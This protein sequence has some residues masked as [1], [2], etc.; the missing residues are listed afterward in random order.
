M[1]Q[2]RRLMLYAPHIPG[3][4]GQCVRLARKLRRLVD[5]TE[6]WQMAI[7]ARRTDVSGEK[8]AWPIARF[9]ALPD[10][11]KGGEKDK[12]YQN[13]DVRDIA[14]LIESNAPPF[15]V[16]L[17]PYAWCTLPLGCTAP[18]PAPLVACVPN[19]EF[20]FL[21]YGLTT[22]QFRRDLDKL[23]RMEAAFVFA[24]EAMRQRAIREFGVAGDRST[25]VIPAASYSG[26]PIDVAR[27]RAKYRLPEKYILCE[28][29]LKPQRNSI[30]LLRALSGMSSELPLV[31]VGSNVDEFLGTPLVKEPYFRDWQVVA[32]SVDAISD[33]D[34]FAVDDI[35]RDDLWSLIAGAAA[36]MA[37]SIA[38]GSVPTFVLDA[39]ALGTPVVHSRIA[40][41]TEVLGD[42]DDVAIGCDPQNSNDIRRALTLA[43]DHSDTKAR[44]IEAGRRLAASRTEF[45]AAR[46]ILE[47]CAAEIDRKQT[48]KPP[49]RVKPAI[50]REQRV[51]WLINHTT[52][53]DFEVPLIQSLG[54][55][56]YTSKLLPKGNDIISITVDYSEDENTTLPTWVLNYLNRQNLYEDHFSPALSEIL[57][58]YF[59]TV[60]CTAVGPMVKELV[61]HY[62]GRI[63]IRVF[64]R[65]H[66]HSYSEY[67]NH[68]GGSRLWES[69]CGIQQRF[70]FAQCYESIGTI[71]QKLIQDRAL[72]LPLG[73]PDRILRKRGDWTG[74]DKR[75]L[76]VCSRIKASPTYYGKIYDEFKLY[77]GDL[78]H[79][80]A[81]TQPLPVNDDCVSGFVPDHTFRLWLREFRVM[82]YHS[83]EPR[84][85]HYHPLEAVVHGMPLIYMKGGLLEGYG[86]DD[87][88]GACDTLEEARKKVIRVLEDDTAFIEQLQQRQTALL[89]EFLWDFNRRAWDEKLLGVALA[90][91]LAK[92]V[93]TID[94]WNHPNTLQQFEPVESATSSNEPIRR[95][96]CYGPPR[97]ALDFEGEL[98][99]KLAAATSTP[100]PVTLGGGATAVSLG[101][102][103]HL[104]ALELLPDHATPML[105]ASIV[106]DERVPFEWN[107]VSSIVDWIAQSEMF[108]NRKFA[109]FGMKLGICGLLYARGAWQQKTLIPRRT[110]IGNYF[111]R[112]LLRLPGVH[113]IFEWNAQRTAQAIAS[114]LEAPIA[115]GVFSKFLV[116]PPAP[117][118]RPL[119][120]SVDV[121][122]MDFAILDAILQT[123]VTLIPRPFGLLSP[124][125]PLERCQP[126]AAVVCVGDLD[127]EFSERHG[128][129]NLS[130]ARTLVLWSRIAHRLIFATH[131]ARDEAVRRYGVPIEK[132]AVIAWPA[133]ALASQRTQVVPRRTLPPRYLLSFDGDAGDACGLELLR[134]VQLLHWRQEAPPPVI[135]ARRRYAGHESSAFYAFKAE[136]ERDLASMK[137][138]RGVEYHII[139]IDND[140][141]LP[142]LYAKAQACV[143]TSR[144]AAIV[145]RIALDAFV[146]RTPVIAPA[147]AETVERF[148]DEN[149][150][151]ELVDANDATAIADAIDRTLVDTNATARRVESA[152][153]FARQWTWE[154]ATRA[155]LEVVNET[156]KWS[157]GKGSPSSVVAAQVS[158]KRRAAA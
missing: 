41:Y 149:R 110:A 153:A 96:L 56:V 108:C 133:L 53:R 49:V 66:P 136:F 33:R 45:D 52:L 150:L 89:E 54:L 11:A 157:T 112:V 147:I 13:A 75:V 97:D 117:T 94:Q 40:A 78:P 91:P 156:A 79:L 145:Q 126:R 43:L 85:L 135:F 34:Y 28:D 114:G 68:F 109:R 69:V 98:T 9:S 106:G 15:D 83:R 93:P 146:Y 1:R 12:A 37:P 144:S 71:E 6:G 101:L 62:R 46:Q 132:T 116:D 17:L 39:L 103:E 88:P 143:T 82:F 86:G 77:F 87:Q 72:T 80:I 19:L 125:L 55:E 81:G 10:R 57:N 111:P 47:V 118:N 129:H 130:M 65:E 20:D 18:I 14:H 8:L 120:E 95:I 21:D 63:M 92:D 64:G 141:E 107:S 115:E 154:D 42:M 137:W 4:D 102:D 134:A 16:L 5:R 25:V 32:K 124:N 38:D 31:C 152:A 128:N 99:R 76:F 138:T 122:P 127:F 73:L 90:T 104:A 158:T 74:T 121:P 84:H 29:W 123:G 44:R 2:G 148:G 142:S 151:L 22:D 7:T 50:G 51:A 105:V 36:V 139:E 100:I 26:E 23:I 119:P 48:S 70:W 3:G 67:L 155:F 30:G 24:S 27:V 131:F 140:G 59:G 113:Q 60:I 61:A 35:T 58:S